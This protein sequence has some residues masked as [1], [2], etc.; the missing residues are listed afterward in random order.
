[1]QEIFPT[2]KIDT[3]IHV[4]AFNN[5]KEVL[6]HLQLTGV[7]AVEKKAWTKKD[8]IAFENNYNNYCGKRPSLTYN[9]IYVHISK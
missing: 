9:P 8:L 5:A 6:K 3:E 2:A 7:N 4:L 1:M